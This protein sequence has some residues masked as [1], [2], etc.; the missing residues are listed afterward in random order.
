[1][2]YEQAREYI[3][4]TGK[5]GMNMGTSRTKRILEL[6]GNP[7]EK[8]KCIHI[9][10]TNGKGSITA[11]I[12]K[13]LME[14]GYKIGMYTS[15]FLEEYE[16]RFQINGV[17]ISKDDLADLITRLSVV[18]DKVIAEGYP[19]PSEFEIGTCAMFLYFYEKKVDYAIVEVGLGGTRDSTNVL[20]PILSIIASISLDHMHIIGNT[21]EDIAREKSGIIKQGAPVIVYPQT[22]ESL[23]IIKD[24]CREKSSNLILVPSECAEYVQGQEKLNSGFSG[25]YTQKISV[26]TDEDSYDINLSLL[27]KHQILN[28]ATAIFAAEELRRQGLNITKENILNALSKVEWHGRLEVMGR[29][30]LVVIDGAHNIDGISKLSESVDRYFE[31]KN[32]VLILGIL[33]DKEVEKMVSVIAPKASRIITVTPNSHRAKAGNELSQVIAKFN[34]N[35]EHADEYEEAYNK[36]LSYCSP[37]DLLLI[38]GSLY[39]IGDMRKIIKNK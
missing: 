3:V 1:M 26:V 25:R 27:G 22:R 28:C 39:M 4:N 23:E 21:I 29:E 9:T 38:S 6:I 36:A 13:I 19:H 33:A 34:R 5:I 18:V 15:P 7:H 17:N 16:E 2:N 11:M 20:H 37:Q 30:P 35:V 14:S 8:L 12:T 10:G 32:M 31:Y 24:V